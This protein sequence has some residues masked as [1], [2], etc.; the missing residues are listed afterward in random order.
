LL[1]FGERRIAVG[2]GLHDAFAAAHL[3]APILVHDALLACE[4]A[5]PAVLRADRLVVLAMGA[6]E[7]H[8][9]EDGDEGTA[10]QITSCLQRQ[11][12]QARFA[13]YLHSSPPEVHEAR[14]ESGQRGF[15]SSARGRKQ[16]ARPRSKNK[17]AT[18][19]TLRPPPSR[20]REARLRPRWPA[21]PPPPRPR[22]P[23]SP[24]RC[25]GACTRRGRCRP[26]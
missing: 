19:T 13:S 7:R 17:T 9:G 23:A 8:R 24:P 10:H 4:A 3:A 6:G 18:R 26:G 14:S 5:L 16:P 15:C 12:S 25:R 2:A 20:L 1:R 21:P 11:R 22:R